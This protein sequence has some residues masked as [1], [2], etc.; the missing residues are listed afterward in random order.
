MLGRGRFVV[1]DK[2]GRHVATDGEPIIVT[3]GLGG[4]H[5]VVL[6]AFDTKAASPVATRR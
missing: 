5:Q 2:P 6:R 4:R 1:R 3:D